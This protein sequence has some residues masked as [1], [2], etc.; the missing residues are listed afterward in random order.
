LF[1]GFRGVFFYRG[2]LLHLL[3]NCQKGSLLKKNKEKSKK[4]RRKTENKKQK[5]KKWGEATRSVMSPDPRSRL[6]HR[7][8]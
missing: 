2:V 4:Y 7:L 5:D 6:D 3:K 8:F 1:S